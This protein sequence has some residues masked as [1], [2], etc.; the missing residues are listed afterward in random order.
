MSASG[1]GVFVASAGELTPSQLTWFDRA[2]RG[3]GTLGET[4]TQNNI[5]FSG[6]E[7]QVLVTRS[8]TNAVNAT[9]VIDRTRGDLMTRVADGSNAIFSPDGKQVAYTAYAQGVFTVP[10]TG[11]R[12]MQVYPGTGW[13]TDWFSDGAS[14][15]IQSPD[16][17]G[18]MD[19]IVLD[20]KT[21]GTTPIAATASNE[22]DGHLSPDDKWIAY[23]SDVS[24]RVEVYLVSIA[25]PTRRIPVSTSGGYSPRWRRDGNELFFLGLDGRSLMSASVTWS[26]GEPRLSKPSELF[27]TG[28][29][30]GSTAHNPF[31]GG[32][33]SPSADGQRF[34]VAQVTKR[35]PGTIDVLVNW[36]RALGE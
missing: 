31:F 19:V 12:A 6:D 1:N 11:G 34:L 23:V 21:G 5:Q 8:D 32:A 20:L 13:A 3:L 14:A 15:V 25:D 10:L 9:F 36:P 17:G 24:S 28:E 26:G 7:S 18:S 2:G 35:I 4:G 27:K 16:L 33:Y 22:A 29:L 30:N